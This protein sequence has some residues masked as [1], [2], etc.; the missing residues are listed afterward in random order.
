MEQIKNNLLLQSVVVFAYLLLIVLSPSIQLMP[1]Y[2][3]SHDGQRLLALLLLSVT[4]I[5]SILNSVEINNALPIT[6]S[7]RWVFIT[8]LLFA[9]LSTALSHFPR[10]AVIEFSIFASLCY[11]SLVVASF[12]LKNRELFIIRIT[13]VLWA[14]TLLYMVGFYVGYITSS[15]SQTPLQWPQPFLGFTNIRLFNQYQLWSIGLITLPI[16]AFKLKK[17]VKIWLS[18][19]LTCWWVLLYY[20]A[21]RGALIA[22]FVGLIFTIIA[23]KKLAL[24][25]LKLQLI[26]AITSFFAYYVLFKII[27][28]IHQQDVV[29]S[30]LIRNNF[31]DRTELWDICF[32]MIE[33]HPLLGVGPQ[34]YFWYTKIGTHPHNSVLQ[35]GAEWGL[36][37]TVIM[38][39]VAGYG[40]YCWYKKFNARAIHV[41]PKLDSMISIILFFTIITNA[42]YSLVDGVIVMPISQ[43]LMFTIIGLMLGQYFYDKSIETSN[44]QQRVIFRPVFASIVL[45]A[46]IWSNVPEIIQGLSGNPRGFSTGPHI[47]NPRIWVQP[48]PN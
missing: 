16:L 18:V 40:F 33:T 45:V 21:S 13:Y 37:A 28:T 26:N 1:N 20:S 48:R 19:S 12:Y 8:L 17:N 36:P 44:M 4:L 7:V 38:I 31:S 34:H 5:Y 43:V 30:T 2:I 15:I 9:T 27:P 29:T 46:L 42:A 39:G 23:Y 41:Q 25:F 22:L 47:V 32:K 10:H 35:L 6:Q 24:P 3:F 14:S 11:V